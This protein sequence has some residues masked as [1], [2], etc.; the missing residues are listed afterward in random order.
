MCCEPRYDPTFWFHTLETAVMPTA[1]P[2][3][4]YA[5]GVSTADSLH[6]LYW[7]IAR[8]MH[9]STMHTHCSWLSSW[10]VKRRSTATR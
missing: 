7:V 4:A 5:S 8:Q 2:S 3:I 1:T 6:A 10:P 9:C